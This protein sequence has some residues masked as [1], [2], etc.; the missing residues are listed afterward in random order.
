MSIL[1]PIGRLATR[2]CSEEM[3]G[4]IDYFRFPERRSSW[5]GPFNG[6]PGRQALF[7][8]IVAQAK[9]AAIIE[10]GTFL[11]TSTD[12]MAAF[13][14]PVFSVEGQR[15]NF[16]YCRT[17]FRGRANI[18]LLLGDSR[19]GLKTL[20]DGPLKDRLAKTL[21]FYLDAHWHEDL[22][23]AEEI[24][25]IFARTDGA[26]CLVD[27]FAVPGDAG[28]V[29]DDYGPGKALDADYIAPLL[30]RFGLTAYYPTLRSA[31]EG[32]LKRGCVAIAK[33]SLH[34]EA[35]RAAGLRAD[36]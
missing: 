20:L 15:R 31:E 8:N 32:G 35:L 10:T 30:R 5:G 16:G 1:S 3:L 2:F 25:I 29:Y 7:R 12:F 26:I 36:V 6:Q 34:G 33:D 21:L 19:E 13:G 4:T 24:E 23:L 22:P 14:L 11:G 27:D 9:P 18:N 17:R 28:Y